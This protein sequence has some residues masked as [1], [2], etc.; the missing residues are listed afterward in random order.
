MACFLSP[1][2]I[3]LSY[4][5]PSTIRPNNLCYSKPRVSLKACTRYPVMSASNSQSMRGILFVCLGNICRSPA[6]EC[7]LRSQLEAASI[8][9]P[10]FV[11]SCGTGG[12]SESWYLPEGHVFHLGDPPDSRMAAAAKD[13][14]IKISGS[15]RPL[16]AE[17]FDK[18]ELILGMDDNNVKE[19]ERVRSFW[20]AKGDAQVRKFGEFCSDDDKGRN[21]PDPYW[22]G[23]KGFELALDMLEDGCSGIVDWAKEQID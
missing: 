14:D 5:T 16:N 4:R 8:S 1:A 7:I 13:R 3:S 17:D 23:A 2:P 21:V 19:I 22:G 11:D 12:G 10:F 9:P 20:N 15:S 6:A 18:F